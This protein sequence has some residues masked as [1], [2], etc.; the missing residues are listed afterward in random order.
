MIF[1]LLRN[2]IRQFLRPGHNEAQAAEFFGGATARVR[3]QESGRRQQ[4][5][6]GIFVHQCSD[7]ARIEWI[8]MEDHSDTRRG[9]KAKGARKTKG[10]EERQ[11]AHDAIVGMQHENLAELRD[12]RSDV[13]MR[14]DHA[15]GIAGRPAG[16]NNRRDVVKCRR[17]LAARVFCD[18]LGWE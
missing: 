6:H 9:G 1:E 8:G 18:Q 5:G 3:I 14:Q 11:N 4:H 10:M 17:P 2:A 12:V 16:K 7:D 15:L 13:V